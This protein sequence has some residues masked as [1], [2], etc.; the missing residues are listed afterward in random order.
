MSTCLSLAITIGYRHTCN[1]N[2]FIFILKSFCFLHFYVLFFLTF[3]GKRS[4]SQ[5]RRSLYQLK[6]IE[7]HS[8]SSDDD[9]YHRIL[10]EIVG[11]DYQSMSDVREPKLVTY[12]LFFPF[13]FSPFFLWYLLLFLSLS[14]TLKFFM[15]LI[16]IFIN[17]R[18]IVFAVNKATTDLKL[19]AF[20]NC[21][22]DEFSQGEGLYL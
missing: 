8:L 18:V 10:R 19:H 3:L 17:V 14:L 5:L 11:V 12:S 15:L 4:V 22:D 1:R 6:D 16:L 9:S 21:F 20:N 2:A 13:L 7:S